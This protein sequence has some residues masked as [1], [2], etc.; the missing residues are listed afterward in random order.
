MTRAEEMVT[1]V[2]WTGYSPVAPATVASALVCA[3]FWF[4]PGAQSLNMIAPLIVLTFI[5][6]WLSNRYIDGY[7]VRDPG[8]F[9]AV[10]RKNPKKDDPDP[11]VFDELVGQ[12]I[13]LLAA[14]HSIV[15][16][17]AAFFLF[18]AFDIFKPL[19]AGQLQ[20]LPRGWG[21]MLDDVL[22]G[23]YAA[24]VLWGLSVWQ[25]NLMNAF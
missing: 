4:I 11:V 23:V 13:T 14:P 6:V 22:A 16:F 10:R 12:W 21:V 25:P 8:K 3:I 24:L 15:G 1:T 17:A 5:G 19:G 20:K 9:A 7:E 2:L 18:R